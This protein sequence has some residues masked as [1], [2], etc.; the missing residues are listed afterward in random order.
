MLNFDVFVKCPFVSVDFITCLALK[1]FNFLRHLP[2]FSQ[3]FGKFV[4]LKVTLKI[5]AMH[6]YR[7][8]FLTQIL[9]RLLWS[10]HLD[11]VTLKLDSAGE[12]FIA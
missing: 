2:R 8:A 12:H 1:R 5:V 10:M 7:T 4:N 3:N 11:N 6:K 9:R